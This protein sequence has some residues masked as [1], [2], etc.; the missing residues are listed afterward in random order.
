MGGEVDDHPAS[1]SQNPH[2]FPTSP[3]RLPPPIYCSVPSPS[4]SGLVPLKPQDLSIS[5]ISYPLLTLLGR[6]EKG[7]GF[8]S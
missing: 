8:V 7:G 2:A 1:E 4:A 5:T 6:K 3:A